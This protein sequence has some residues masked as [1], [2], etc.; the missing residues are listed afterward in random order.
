MGDLDL[1]IFPL[2]S[3]RLLLFKN[4]SLPEQPEKFG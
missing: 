1:V 2:C 4:P 3:L